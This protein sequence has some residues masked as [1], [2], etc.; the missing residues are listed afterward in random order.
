MNEEYFMQIALKEAEKSLKINE[1]P[2]GA[3][4][5]KNNK[6]IAKAHNIKE[7]KQDVTKHAEIIAIQKASKKLK[8]WHLNDC[9]I[10]I[11]LEPCVMCMGA[12][13]QSRMEKI[14]YATSSQK[15]G[16]SNLFNIDEQNKIL[17]LEDICKEESIK[18]LQMF[19]KNKR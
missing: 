18:L 14:V 17:I 16:Y 13:M 1:V 19:F 9:T 10:Y 5:V 11:T 12:I 8:D 15:F 6:I 4:I 2:V 3:V 7:K